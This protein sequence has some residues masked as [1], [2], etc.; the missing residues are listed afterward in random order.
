[1]LDVTT[2]NKR[3]DSR[4]LDQNVDGWT[5]GVLKWITNGVSDDSGVL[6][7]LNC[8]E[9]PGPLAKFGV[10]GITGVHSIYLLDDF[11]WVDTILSSFLHHSLSHLLDFLLAV[12]PGTTGVRVN[13]LR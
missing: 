5:G 13:L 9:L 1:M 3:S 12:I 4:E 2:E 8:S 10:V 7:V 11:V 6:L